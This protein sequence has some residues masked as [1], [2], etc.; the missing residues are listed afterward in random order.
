MDINYAYLP[1]WWSVE[2]SHSQYNYATVLHI[3]IEDYSTAYFSRIAMFEALYHWTSAK[4]RARMWFVDA[5]VSNKFTKRV[6]AL[7]LVQ[8]YDTSNMA[9]WLNIH[10]GICILDLLVLAQHI[11][12]YYTPA[13][14]LFLSSSPSSSMHFSL[15][16]VNREYVLKCF[17]HRYPIIRET[18]VHKFEPSEQD[19]VIKLSH[20]GVWGVSDM[21]FITADKSLMCIWPGYSNFS[22]SLL[23]PP[24][25]SFFPP[26]SPS[27]LSLLS[28]TPL[29]SPPPFNLS[30][31]GARSNQRPQNWECSWWRCR[32][33]GITIRWRPRFHCS[34]ADKDLTTCK[35]ACSSPSLLLPFLHS[36]TDHESTLT[37]LSWFTCTSLSSS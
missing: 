34:E 30:L 2:S 13:S 19:Q 7:P 14:L 26:L 16:Q 12:I 21:Y 24:L 8:Q 36:S 33:V 25:L 31:P 1:E 3:A 18:A 10:G 23:L 37:L 32:K 22:P 11:P 20:V 29:S 5:W 4:G 6:W 35:Q 28:L 17:V 15:L 9:M 27:S